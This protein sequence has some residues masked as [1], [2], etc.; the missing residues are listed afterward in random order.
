MSN[1]DKVIQ[2]LDQIILASETKQCPMGYFAALYRKVTIAIVKGITEG[3]FIDGS[4]MEKLDCVFA[5]RYIDAY[6]AYQNHQVISRSWKIAFDSASNNAPIVLQHLLLGINAH[7]SLDL[8]IAAAQISKPNE[9]NALKEDFDK[10]N[11]ILF[12]LIIDVEND[13]ENICPSLKWVLTKTGKVDDFLIGYS[14]EYARDKAWNFALS[15]VGEKDNILKQR[16]C[17]QDRK[18]SNYAQKIIHPGFIICLFFLI[19]RIVEKG[20]VKQKITELTN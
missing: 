17:I 2:E 18:V 9:M 14:M 5:Y 19:L 11:S 6:Y 8:G 12:S 1:I 16:I 13:L 3:F 20:S 4:K 7:I 15:L 10:I